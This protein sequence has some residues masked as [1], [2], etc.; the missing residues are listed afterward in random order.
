MPSSGLYIAFNEATE[1]LNTHGV[2]GNGFADDC[3][4]LIG[5]KNLDQM[6]SR[7]QKVVTNLE[8]WGKNCGLIF[9]PSKTEVILF[10]KAHNISRKAPNKLIIGMQEIPF[11]LHAKYPGVILDNKLLWHKHLNQPLGRLDNFCLFYVKPSVKN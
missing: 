8:E 6:M 5:G 1:I 9:N 10:S 4:A 11:T 7:M 3:V 2:Y